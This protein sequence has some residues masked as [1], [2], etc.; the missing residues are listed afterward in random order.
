[1][2]PGWFVDR[3]DKATRLDA[4]PGKWPA[5]RVPFRGRHVDALSRVELEGRLRAIH[6]QVKTR[7]RVAEFGLQLEGLSACIEWHPGD[8]AL[9]NEDIVKLVLR[10]EG[11]LFRHLAGIRF[12]RAARDPTLKRQVILC[13]QSGD[14]PFGGCAAP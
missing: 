3:V 5:A 1:M 10:P 7:V 13:R 14:S 6:L 4:K 2:P 8:L 9:H 11:E 12:D